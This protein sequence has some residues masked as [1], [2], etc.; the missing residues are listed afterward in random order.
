MSIQILQAETFE[1]HYHF[2]VWMDTTKSLAD[3]S[4]D[5]AYIRVVDYS[6]NFPEGVA[7]EAAYL[8]WIQSEIRQLVQLEIQTKT[9]PVPAANRVKQMIGKML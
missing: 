3:G 1:D 9:A 6:K 5:P 2:E 8:V 4:P 7:D